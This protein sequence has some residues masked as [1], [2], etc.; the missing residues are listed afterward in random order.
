[1]TTV[2][3]GSVAPDFVYTT[4]K[5][6]SRRLSELWQDRPALVLWLRHFG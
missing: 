5:G 3:P 2:G 1:M 4:G 6:E